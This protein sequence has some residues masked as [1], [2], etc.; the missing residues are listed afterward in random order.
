MQKCAKERRDLNII[1]LLPVFIL[2]AR[3]RVFS[4][5]FSVN[6]GM[7]GLLALM[8]TLA[9]PTLDCQSTGWLLS[10]NRDS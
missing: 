10:P 1:I 5:M 3:V 7:I 2:P 9:K 8:A 4:L 6:T